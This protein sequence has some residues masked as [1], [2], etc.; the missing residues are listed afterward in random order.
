MS[1]PA[2]L[3][4]G[5]TEKLILG[6]ICPDSTVRRIDMNGRNVRI[7]SMATKIASIIRTLGNRFYPIVILV[8]REGREIS[9]KDMEEKLTEELE[10]L[11]INCN[12]IVGVADKMIENWIIADWDNIKEY[13]GTKDSKP[14]IT[15]GIGGKGAIKKVLPDYQETLDG[16][17]LFIG[18]NPH[19]MKENSPSFNS[20]SQKIQGI[21]CDW[22]NK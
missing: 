17:Q 21:K 3:I 18:S 19:I 4:D 10:K 2:F 15:D 6:R 11:D 14:E 16:V 1:K 22:I 7:S 12:L 8:D 13:T 20:F 9:K 5:Y